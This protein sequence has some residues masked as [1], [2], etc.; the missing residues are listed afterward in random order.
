MTG[1]NEFVKGVIVVNCATRMC[2]NE[3][4]GIVPATGF[5]DEYII[6]S[7][8]IAPYGKQGGVGGLGK[9]NGKGRKGILLATIHKANN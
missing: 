7:Y 6:L 5:H 8:D 9:V 3:R 2:T 4:K 1:A